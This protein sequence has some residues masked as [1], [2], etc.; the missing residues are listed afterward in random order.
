MKTILFVLAALVT[1]VLAAPP[2]YSPAEVAKSKFTLV[3]QPIGLFAW[4]PEIQEISAKESRVDFGDGLTMTIPN[5]AK[6][7]IAALDPRGLL[8][9]YVRS[10]EA[11]KINIVLLGNHV[12]YDINGKPKFSWQRNA[13][14]L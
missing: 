13:D 4:K 11:R 2:H 3:N 14:K 7:Q 5:S 10:V 1:S 6:A 12:D 8:Y 9:V